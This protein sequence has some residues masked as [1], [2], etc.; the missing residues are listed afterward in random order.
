MSISISVNVVLSLHVTCLTNADYGMDGMSV[1]L[2]D[3]QKTIVLFAPSPHNLRWMQQ[4]C[5]NQGKLARGLYSLEYGLIE[6][7]DYS[8][9]IFIPSGWLHATFTTRGGF[10]V[11]ID[12]ATKTTVWTFSE[13]LKYQLFR[14]LDTNQQ[15]ECF[16]LFLTCLEHTLSSHE[17]TLASRAWCN[18]DDFLKSEMDKTWKQ[19]ASQI[20][21]K[22]A[23]ENPNALLDDGMGNNELQVHSFYKR[24]LSWLDVDRPGLRRGR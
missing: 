1:V 14:E 7:L 4:E 20:W 15:D 22:A 5:R 16:F 12:C 21:G 8:A 18:V 13:Y 2:G 3:C 19:S 6:K 9:I 23:N 10:L 11:S 17:L 24:Y